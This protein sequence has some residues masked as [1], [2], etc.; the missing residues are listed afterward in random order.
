MFESPRE[1]SDPDRPDCG[2]S[3]NRN[4]FTGRHVLAELYDASHT[5]L[6]DPS[7][8][9]E[10]LREALTH[11]GATVCEI[12]AHQF[13]PQGVTVLAMLS[14]SHA[15]IH[16]YPETG[17]AFVDIFT[18]GDTADPELAVRTLATELAAGSLRSRTVPRGNVTTARPPQSSG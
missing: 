15:S 5:V 11:A 3:T 6:D 7:T 16:T 9:R 1:H 4:G 14:E 17:S 10:T 13:T 18:C 8:L 12:H 2:H